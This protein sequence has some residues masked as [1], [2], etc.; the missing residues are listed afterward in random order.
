VSETDAYLAA[1]VDYAVLDAAKR[2]A[3]SAAAATSLNP[4]R[5]GAVLDDSSRGEPA[6]VISVGDV[7]LGFVLECL[8][9][10]SAIAF[11]LETETEEDHWA[12]V[13]YDTVAAA[14]NDCCCVGALPFV[15][16][17]YFATGAATFYTGTRHASLVAGFAA[18]CT[19]AGAAWG[20]GE[21]PT[22]SGVIAEDAIDLAAA[23]VG[24]IPDGVAPITG[25]AL[26]AGD[27]IVLVASTGLHA[28]GASL[29]RRVAELLPYGYRTALSD[30]ESFGAAALRPSAL[31]VRVVESLFANEIPVHYLSHITG[32]G[33]RKLMRANRNFTYRIEA[34]PA[35]PEVL[36][37]LAEAAEL[38]PHEA[39][40]TL[41][42]GAGFAI[43][44][45]AGAGARVV[46]L[47]AELGLDATLAGR[48]E[49]G[50]R[51]VVLEPAGVSYTADDL[52]LR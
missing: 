28:N 45:A 36:A 25:A 24:R 14:V 1:G 26:S 21:S 33:L 13:G 5:L 17:A 3:L 42:M 51:A 8:G 18:A 19:D 40:G 31:Y 27:E 50:P 43:Y 10:K 39:Y 22:L 41:N 23:A 44:V 35:V 34:L 16:N 2:R 46:E 47:C 20:G 11:A 49:D 7:H 15:V 4:S 52:D 9:T 12:A 30:G 37:F 29:V 38:L 32:H 6:V 48:V